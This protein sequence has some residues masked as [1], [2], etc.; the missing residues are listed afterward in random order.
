MAAVIEALALFF[1]LAVSFYLGTYARWAWRQNYRRGAAGILLVAL[2][3][4]AL[5]VAV[6]AYH[7]YIR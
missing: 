3:A 2:I 1:L 4:L 7:Q 5:P 6:W